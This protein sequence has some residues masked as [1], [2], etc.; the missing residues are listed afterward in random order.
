MDYSN[1]FT[2]MNT[3]RAPTQPMF[4]QRQAPAP[5]DPQQFRQFAI[6]LNDNALNNFAQMAR[7]QGI[8]E[9]DIQN[10]IRFIKSM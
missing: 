5:I 1:P 9:A 7:Q 8:S 6:T 3:M 10:G 2:M 4:G